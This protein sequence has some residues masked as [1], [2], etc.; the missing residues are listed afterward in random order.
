MQYNK[1]C[2]DDDDDDKNSKGMCVKL[3]FTFTFT[4]EGQV[5]NLYVTVS[6]QTEIELPSNECPYE[7]IFVPIPGLSMERNRYPTFQK[8]GCVVFLINTVSEES[9]HLKNREHYHKEVYNPCMEYIHKVMHIF[10]NYGKV[11]VSDEFQ[12]VGWNDDDIMIL[13]DIAKEEI[14]KQ[15]IENSN[16]RCKQSEKR[17]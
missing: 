6:G 8:H 14:G 4:G 13:D 10:D 15:F 9:I 11:E 16:I 2:D 5:F 7:V 3:T 17:T 1:S 12:S